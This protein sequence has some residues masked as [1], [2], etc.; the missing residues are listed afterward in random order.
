MIALSEPW[1]TTLLLIGLVALNTFFIWRAERM[2]ARHSRECQETIDAL[3]KRVG[4]ARSAEI[5]DAK[6]RIHDMFLDRA[7]WFSEHEP[8]RIAIVMAANAYNEDRATVVAQW[9]EALA[10][11]DA[12]AQVEAAKAKRPRRKKEGS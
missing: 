8:T 7:G 10:R 11:H 1:G 12:I 2:R 9:R 4:Q 3:G 6:G 5:A